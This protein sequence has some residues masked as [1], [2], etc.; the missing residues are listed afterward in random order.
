MER[1]SGRL[2]YEAPKLDVQELQ[3]YAWKLTG[4]KCASEDDNNDCSG[5]NNEQKPWWY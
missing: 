5:D 2:D 4:S 1:T 3:A